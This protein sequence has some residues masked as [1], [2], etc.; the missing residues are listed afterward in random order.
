MLFRSEVLSTLKPMYKATPFTL[1]TDLEQ[2]IQMDSFPGPLGQIITNFMTNALAHGFEGRNKGVMRIHSKLLDQHFLVVTF[3]DDGIGISEGNIKRV[4][5]PFFTTKL[6]QGGSGLGLNIA[7][8]L[9]T[10]VLGGTLKL[11]SKV[12]DG[13]RFTMVLPLIAPEILASEE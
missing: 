9:V 5:D 10:G 2:N 4:F 13:T 6:G 3:S 8:N 1:E 7:Y 12:G 11:D